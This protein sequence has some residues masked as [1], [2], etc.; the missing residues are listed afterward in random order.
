MIYEFLK[1]FHRR[2][3]IIAIVDFITT[4]VA[5]KTKLREFGFEASETI[6]LVMLVLCFIMEK[7]L[8]EEACTKNDVANFIRRL[9][10]EFLKKNIPD[11]EYLGI[12]DYII[13]DCLQNSGIPHY[14]STYNFEANRE[15]KINVKLIDDKRISV[16]NDNVYTYYMTPQGYKFMFNTLEIE[17]ALKVSIEQ[18]KLNLSIKKRNFNAARNNADSLFNISKT[19]IQRINYF[20]KRVK[21]DIGSA[22]IEE[23][24]RI[25]NSTFSS[26]DE[27][28]E[29]YD[30]LYELIGRVENSIIESNN[31]GIQKEA[32]TKEIEDISYI[33]NRLKFIINEQSNLLLK[34]QQLQKIYNE[35]VDNILYI[36]FENRINFEDVIMKKLEENPD[37]SYPLIKVLRP[38]FMPDTNKFFNIKMALG[39]Q[40]IAMAETYSEGSN[41]LMNERYFNRFESERDIRIRDINNKY[42]D[43]F[44]IICKQALENSEKEILL[45]TLVNQLRQEYVKFV[46]DLKILTNVLLQL[47]N[48]KEVDFRTIKGQRNKTVFNPSEAFDIKYCVLELLNRDKS[49]NSIDCLKILLSRNK[50]VFIAEKPLEEDSDGLFSTE[51]VVGLNCPDILFKIEVN[52]H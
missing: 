39:E 46:P 52:Q 33:K 28:K 7:S 10:V 19:Q 41:I 27:Q 36:G 22:G 17:D 12:V 26:I 34:Q 2:A 43:I 24:E 8:V 11:E 9:D 18:F 30:N 35:A 50:K 3:E 29:G 25:Y 48:I 13:K 23:Y 14:F 5:R 32:L 20:I 40:R 21:E 16:G 51:K 4:R 45:S 6:N 1:D 49:Y 15:E 47:C 38:L 44:E 37:L 42:I 31:N